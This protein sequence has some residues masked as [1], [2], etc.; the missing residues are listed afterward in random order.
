MPKKKRAG[1]VDMSA[2][3]KRLNAYVLFLHGFSRDE[4]A[5]ACGISARTVS[6]W[7]N[8]D[9]WKLDREAVW[10]AGK[11][12]ALADIIRPLNEGRK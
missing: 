3:R 8:Q 5:A 10:L 1:K 12:C 6:R 7:A 11:S 2:M 4:I 9:G